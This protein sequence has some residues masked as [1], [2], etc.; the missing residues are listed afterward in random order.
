MSARLIYVMGPSGAGK[1]SVLQGLRD[2]WADLPTA[3]WARRTITRA[4][5]PDGEAHESVTQQEFDN[6]D[7]EGAFAMAWQ[8]NGLAYG[9]RREELKP[10]STGHCVFVNGSRAYLS[11]VLQQWPT[12]TVVHINASADVLLQRLNSRNRESVQDISE[13][14][15]RRIAIDLPLDAISI[16]NDGSLQEAVQSLRSQLQARLCD[17]MKHPS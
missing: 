5:Q 16:V 17:A 11:Q 13:R 9:I 6:L 1:D 7:Q 12:L 8:A 4:T 2:T 10:L 3:H 14:M 15:S